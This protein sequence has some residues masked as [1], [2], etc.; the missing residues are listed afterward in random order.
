MLF[1]TNG[2]DQDEIW[3]RILK[4]TQ[5]IIGFDDHQGKIF[6]SAD[7]MATEHRIERIPRYWVV[8]TQNYVLRK[9]RYGVIIGRTKKNVGIRKLAVGI[10]LNVGRQRG[11]IDVC[12][13]AVMWSVLRSTR[14][15]QTAY[16]RTLE[17]RH[18]CT[19]PCW[20]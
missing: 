18:S 13:R 6:R 12:Y 7:S 16:R 1:G 15:D 10:V 20:K 14:Q 17:L 3:N 5:K 8:Q 11:R 2:P 9:I 4:K 19:Y